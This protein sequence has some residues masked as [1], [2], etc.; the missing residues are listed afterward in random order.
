MS[1]PTLHSPTSITALGGDLQSGGVLFGL[2]VSHV[3]VL[4]VFGC[5]ITVYL[6]LNCAS[7]SKVKPMGLVN[8]ADIEYGTCLGN[9]YYGGLS[10][11]GVYMTA[12]ERKAARKAK[13]RDVEAKDPNNVYIQ[14]ISSTHQL[15]NWTK[16]SDNYLNQVVLAH[17][18]H[19]RESGKMD[20]R[21]ETHFNS[22]QLT[23]PDG[24]DQGQATGIK[25]D[26]KHL[27]ECVDDILQMLFGKFVNVNSPNVVKFIG[28]CNNP[29]SI[30][31]SSIECS[32]LYGLVH[33]TNPSLVDDKRCHSYS[34]QIANGL[35]YLGTMNFMH[36]DLRPANVLVERHSDLVKLTNFEIV[37]C[38]YFDIDDAYSGTGLMWYTAPEIF[39]HSNG[40]LSLTSDVYA[41]G[42][43]MWEILNKQLPFAESLQRLQNKDRKEIVLDIIENHLRPQFTL[44]EGASYE[45]QQYAEVA[46][47]CWNGN[48]KERPSLSDIKRRL[49]SLLPQ[50]GRQR[51]ASTSTS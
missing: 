43:V 24:P 6:L 1:T 22:L 42:I 50:E 5:L 21:L 46:R 33:L 31:K 29:R 13:R 27:N 32:Q 38:K 45:S 16:S 18:N 8:I 25:R 35:A 40:S 41:L 48:P 19:L 2:D 4:V 47:A 3:L 39:S 49:F 26:T 34:Y 28:Y 23:V 14:S 12:A 20:S 30:V 9:G 36:G 7:S 11:L 37:L 15:T 10:Y 51:L 17:I 44:P